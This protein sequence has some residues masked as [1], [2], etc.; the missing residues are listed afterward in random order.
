MGINAT[1]AMDRITTK[2]FM[3]CSN[4]L[5]FEPRILYKKHWLISDRFVIN[6]RK[7]PCCTL[8]APTDNELNV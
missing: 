3:W 6:D 8:D 5:I 7:L 1:D 2:P 4:W